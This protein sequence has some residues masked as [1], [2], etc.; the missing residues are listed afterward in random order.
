M[1]GNYWPVE[2][3]WG[4]KRESLIENNTLLHLNQAIIPLICALY[5][6]KQRK[7]FIVFRKPTV[8]KVIPKLIND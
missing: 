8:K 5:L 6:Y 2:I 3:H 7:P 4:E 1:V